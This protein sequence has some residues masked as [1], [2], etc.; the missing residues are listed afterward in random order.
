MM[1]YINSIGQ[2]TGKS[3]ASNNVQKKAMRKARVA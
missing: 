1:K 2:K 3:N